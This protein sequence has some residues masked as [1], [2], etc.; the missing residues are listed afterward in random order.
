MCIDFFMKYQRVSK[1][2]SVYTCVNLFIEVCC[3]FELRPFGVHIY[4]TFLSE[5][6]HMAFVLDGGLQ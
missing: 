4:S 3:P 5:C 1:N 2:N 6:V